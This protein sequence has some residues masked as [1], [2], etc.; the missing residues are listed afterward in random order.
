MVEGLVVFSL[1]A[2][3]FILYRPRRSR[4]MRHVTRSYNGLPYGRER[5]LY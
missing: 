1:V 5:E 2:I 3:L 4:F